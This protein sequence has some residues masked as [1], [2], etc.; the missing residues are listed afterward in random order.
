MLFRSVSQLVRQIIQ[1]KIVG[2]SMGMP[3]IPTMFLLYI[4]FRLGGAV[5]LIIAVPVGMIVYNLY[6]AGLFSNTIRSMQILITD[7]NE[8]RKID[9][10][11]DKNGNEGSCL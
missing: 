10:G 7:I 6:K 1:P 4:G 3:A 11:N 2:D 5:G 8:F 9:E